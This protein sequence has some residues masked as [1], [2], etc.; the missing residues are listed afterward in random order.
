MIKPWLSKNFLQM[1][2][3]SN[4][5]DYPPKKKKPWLFDNF[6]EMEEIHS[7]HMEE[8]WADPG[9]APPLP[10]PPDIPQ[11]PVEPDP[12]VGDRTLWVT[13]TPSSVDC[14]VG[15]D[16]TL[17]FSPDFKCIELQQAFFDEDGP[18]IVD[19]LGN[20]LSIP[21]NTDDI[22]GGLKLE[23][24]CDDADSITLWASDC[25]CGG[26]ASVDI[27]LDNCGANCTGL[28]V[29]GSSLMNPNSQAYF[30]LNNSQGDVTFF[31]SGAG[32]S[33]NLVTGLLT[34][35]ANA[36][37]MVLVWAADSC[38]GTYFFN[39]RVTAG[40]WDLL[41]EGRGTCESCTNFNENPRPTDCTSIQGKYK[42]TVGIW[43]CSD[44]GTA[45]CVTKGGCINTATGIGWEVHRKYEWKCLP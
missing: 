42:Y 45:P 3:W 30:G 12:C 40:Y 26:V 31:A 33:M 43:G 29:W 18:K 23:K 9:S 2:T 5:R 37:G 14:A 4:V 34:L 20:D 8:P 17:L 1:M 13:A 28:S 7:D 41:T 32:A 39:V 27:F 15:V 38:C 36:C 16:F 24:G 6:M 25:L 21:I 44:G 11:D 22:I 35:N 10:P 19:Q